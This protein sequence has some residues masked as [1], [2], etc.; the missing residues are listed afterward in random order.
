MT[1]RPIW[2]IAREVESNW[3][4]VYNYSAGVHLSKMNRLVLI[5]DND[6]ELIV[7]KF[8]DNAQHWKGDIAKQIKTEL[9][10]MLCTKSKKG[11]TNGTDRSLQ[12]R[13][14]R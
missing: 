14:M 3:K 9:K 1:H 12:H 10:T 4:N 8:L 2:V 5:S 7:S 6:A 13:S 11:N